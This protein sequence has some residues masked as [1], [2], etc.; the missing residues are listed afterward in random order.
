MTALLAVATFAIFALWGAPLARFLPQGVRWIAAPALGVAL[1]SLLGAS[2]A[3]AN[4]PLASA[5]PWL[6]IAWLA[7]LVVVVPWCRGRS[8][9]HLLV[10]TPCG[11]ELLVLLAVLALALAVAWPAF[12]VGPTWFG[13]L[14]PDGWSYVVSADYLAQHPRGDVVGEVAMSADER[15]RQPWFV[16]AGATLQQRLAAYSLLA[17]LRISL[18]QQDAFFAWAPLAIALLATSGATLVLIARTLGFGCRAALF[19]GCCWILAPVASMGLLIQFLGQQ[20]GHVILPLGVAVCGAADVARPG[21]YRLLLAL[22]WGALWAA[23]PEMAPLLALATGIVLL[24]DRGVRA[25]WSARL[26]SWIAPPVLGLGL[27]HVGASDSAKFVIGQLTSFQ[28]VIGQRP[29]DGVFAWAGTTSLAPFWLGVADEEL[30]SG[31]DG[32]GVLRAATALSPLLLLLLCAGWAVVPRLRGIALGLVLATVVLSTKLIVWDHYPYAAAKIAMYVAWIV[33]LG[34]AGLAAH[35]RRSRSRA[36]VRIGLGFVLALWVGASAALTFRA[37][38]LAFPGPRSRL[39]APALPSDA[40]PDVIRR[41]APA[42]AAEGGVM[43]GAM[44]WSDQLWCVYWLRGQPLG[45]WRAQTYLTRECAGDTGHRIFHR[46][47]F[48][49]RWLIADPQLEDVLIRAFPPPV[50][51]AGRL[52]WYPFE[53]Y[54]DFDHADADWEMPAVLGPVHEAPD[55]GRVRDVHGSV[56]L[57]IVRPGPAPRALRA[58][59]WS[60]TGHGA[61]RVLLDQQPLRVCDLSAAPVDLEVP[62]PL[63]AEQVHMLELVPVPAAGAAQPGPPRFHLA[64]ISILSREA[65]IASFPTR[66]RPGPG[67]RGC[68]LGIQADGW[69]AS[70]AEMRLRVPR[71]ATAVELVVD[72]SPPDALDG[73]PAELRIKAEVC[74][75]PALELEETALTLRH[76]RLGHTIAVPGADQERLVQVRLRATGGVRIQADPR[77]FRARLVELSSR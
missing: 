28:G 40:P 31:A 46:N 1:L 58:T 73:G 45:L 32:V 2:L 67:L 47:G 38:S 4:V 56:R 34:M 27:L 66:I 61:V 63:G 37:G 6:W 8:S 41:G 11:Y 48:R 64:S 17:F 44:H 71:G 13:Y 72:P 76:T 39:M 24:C 50:A 3:Y 30:A 5:V 62:L 74:G 51:P 14:N 57:R 53:G 36:G 23:Y 15:H 75:E 22:V 25:S 16:E 19:A 18:G 49:E 20:L 29:G 54:V 26:V 42:H 10:R 35:S 9:A 60:G 55:G 70:V 68:S 69:L 65:W 59:M 21:C 43:V 12:V 52:A 33:P 7:V 77:V